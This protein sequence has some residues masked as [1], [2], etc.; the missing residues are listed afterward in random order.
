[1]SQT[2]K[3]HKDD[4]VLLLEAGFVSIMHQDEDSTIKLFKAAQLLDPENVMPKIGMAYMHLL[5]LDL[6]PA[7]SYIKQALNKEPKNEFAQALYGVILTFSPDM[8]AE[9]A[10]LLHKTH[11]HTSDPDIRKL[12]K[13]AEDFY[14]KYIK[15]PP[16]PA[17]VLSPKRH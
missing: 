8:G 7:I 2:F 12:T 6:R 15:T 13:N 3:K 1:M 11:E 10:Q 9:G 5:K 16:S 17:D 4:F 14:T